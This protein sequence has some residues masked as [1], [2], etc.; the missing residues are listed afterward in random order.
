MK[1]I[2][3]RVKSASVTVENKVVGQIELGYLLL[4]GFTHTDTQEIALKMAQKIA[5]LRIMSDEAG[6][7]NNT[8]ADAGG[9]ILAVPQFTL[10][11]DTSGRRP[12]FKDAAK[13]EEAKALFD[14]FVA[15]LKKQNLVVA[16]GIFGAY[17]IVASKNDGPLTLDLEL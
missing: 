1:I 6:K 13:P 2:L 17:M 10:Y 15:E 16:Q 5:N 11:A 8:I 12:G 9:E 4:I 7:M 3:Q 14:F